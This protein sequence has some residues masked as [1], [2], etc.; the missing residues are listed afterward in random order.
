MNNK[1][2]YELQLIIEEKRRNNGINLQMP[3]LMAASL[4][5]KSCAKPSGSSGGKVTSAPQKIVKPETINLK[6]TNEENVSSK[7]G[8][9]GKKNNNNEV[10]TEFKRQT[11]DVNNGGQVNNQNMEENPPAQGGSQEIQINSSSVKE[12]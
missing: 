11:L 2:T 1:T 4:L 8:T 3:L 12:K 6:T 9:D 7:T 10:I 5:A